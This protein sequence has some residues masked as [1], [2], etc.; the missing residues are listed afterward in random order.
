MSAIETAAE[1]DVDFVVIAAVVP[2]GFA[3]G[4]D[5]PCRGCGQGRDPVGVVAVLAGGEEGLV[6]HGFF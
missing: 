3:E 6:V 4:E 2:A 1:Q 5:R